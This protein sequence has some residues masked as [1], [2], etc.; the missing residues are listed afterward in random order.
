MSTI[1]H[2]FIDIG[3]A[4]TYRDN[5][6]YLKCVEE[7]KKRHPEFTIKIWDERMLD[8][9]VKTKYKKYLTFWNNFP[10]PFWKIDFGRYLILASEGGIYVDMDDIIIETIDLNK[11]YIL[12]NYT[13]DKTQKTEFCNNIIYYKERSIYDDLIKFSYERCQK[14]KMPKE[15]KVRRFLYCVGARMYDQFNKKIL[16]LDP[17][18]I[19]STIKYKS[20]R[21]RSW[22]KSHGKKVTHH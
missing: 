2:I 22:L 6:I 21:T 7:N 5:P 4:K 13:S 3:L 20:Y 10:N 14:C 17:N 18:S 16:G 15:W 8:N 11:E 9:L 19:Q 12:V 1:H